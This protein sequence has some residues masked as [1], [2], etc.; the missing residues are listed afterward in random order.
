MQ[1]GPA[2]GERIMD[3]PVRNEEGYDYTGSGDVERTAAV[4]VVGSSALEI[5]AGAAGVVLTII[6]LAVEGMHPPWLLAVSSIVIGGAFLARGAALAGWSKDLSAYTG[7]TGK[8]ALF[9]GAG[10]ELLGGAAGVVF[11]VLALI[12]L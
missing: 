10:I 6:G 7:K 12:G 5:L 8:T 11:G 1:A 4:S 2:E 3:P 9:G